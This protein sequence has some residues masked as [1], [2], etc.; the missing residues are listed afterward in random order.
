MNTIAHKLALILSCSM[1]TQV[2]LAEQE[3]DFAYSISND[4]VTITK[5]TGKEAQIS[6]PATIKGKKVTTIGAGRDRPVL[7]GWEAEGEPGGNGQKPIVAK[8]VVPEGVLAID[9]HA[10]ANCDDLVEISLPKS[11]TSIGMGAFFPCSKLKGISIPSGVSRIEESTF[12]YCT[13]LVSV[14]LPANLVEIK[15]GAFQHC[16]NLTSISFPLKLERIGSQAFQSTG[17][18]KVTIPASVTEIGFNAFYGC[19][20]LASATFEGDVPT[21]YGKGTSPNGNTLDDYQNVFLDGS[22]EF[23]I[24][25]IK[26]KSG[27]D[28]PKW[29]GQKMEVVKPSK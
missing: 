26:G 22:P 17:I 23:T 3:G 10:F 1:V 19:K 27:F 11:L 9:T 18:T 2:A 28:S 24:R 16:S 5:Y 7:G 29:N 13:S 12:K 21:S 14:V 25:Y 4:V 20:A 8:V 15:A 6:F